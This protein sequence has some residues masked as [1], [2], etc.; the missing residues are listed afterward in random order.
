M[1]SIPKTKK[2]KPAKWSR[3]DTI[4]FLEKLE[5]YTASGLAI[6]K[7]IEIA[8]AGSNKKQTATFCAIQT[9]I[10]NGN[11]LAKAMKNHVKVPT[12]ILSLISQGESG[13]ELASS[14]GFA[15]VLLEREEELI[16]K[17]LSAL[18]YPFV[19]GLFA[20]ALTVG[21]MK[22]VMPQIIPL[23][24]SL[25]VKLPF[26]TRAVMNISDA[27][28]HY[29]LYGLLLVTSMI[30]VWVA[31]YARSARFRFA[32]QFFLL[33]VPIAGKLFNLYFASLFARSLGSQIE[34]GIP[35]AVAYRETV[36]A[37]NYLPIKARYEANL[38]DINRGL[39]LSSVLLGFKGL[40][41][42]FPSLVS[43]GELTGTLGLS[44]ARSS[45]IIDRDIEYSLKKLTSLVEPLMMVVMGGAIAA[46]ALAIIMPIYDVSKVLQH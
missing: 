21:L 13:G 20:F 25:N 22:G 40:P 32:A 24:K 26:I 14:L 34:A 19:I 30:V 18:T 33:K 27:L 35:V 7:A 11:N 1:T 43:A 28:T 12:A 42:F 39:S 6:N 41:R 23:L 8:A 31:L 5:L 17:C 3:K 29:G 36:S 46:I 15:R 2:S 37:M 16:K 44:L 10:E 45:D 38:K 4:F 9:D